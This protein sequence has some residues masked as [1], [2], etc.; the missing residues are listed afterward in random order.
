[1][2]TI[3]GQVSG[4]HKHPAS[5]HWAPH[6]TS[7]RC[8]GSHLR[9]PSACLS[10]VCL[11]K[12][13]FSLPCEALSGVQVYGN[14]LGSGY[15]PQSKPM[16]DLQN[17]PTV[18]QG[19][20]SANQAGR[21]HPPRSRFQWVRGDPRPSSSLSMELTRLRLSCNYTGSRAF[22][23]QAGARACSLRA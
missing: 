6:P 18:S 3:G 8:P 7:P 12:V 17:G 13:L 11:M 4:L 16:S 1:M 21:P 20:A 19:S 23:A 2:E 10:C 5:P 14:F 15:K 22:R 9:I